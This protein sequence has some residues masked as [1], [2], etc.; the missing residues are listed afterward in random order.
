MF[1]NCIALRSFVFPET[2]SSLPYAN[3]S[4]DEKPFQTDK[5]YTMYLI[6]LKSTYAFDDF[7][8]AWCIDLSKTLNDTCELPPLPIPLPPDPWQPPN[9]QEK[10]F[11]PSNEDHPFDNGMIAFV[12]IIVVAL[13]AVAGF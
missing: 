13:L 2:I 6:Y 1:Q 9:D 4:P 11:I 3:G 7:G 10:Q 12:V 8:S 5:G